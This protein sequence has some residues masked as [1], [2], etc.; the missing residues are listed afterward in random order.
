MPNYYEV[1]GVSKTTSHDEITEAYE[2]KKVEIEQQ[3]DDA[4][5]F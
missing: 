4:A 1:L 5:N 2:S 3:R